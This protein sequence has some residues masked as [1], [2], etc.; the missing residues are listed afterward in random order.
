[1]YYDV[2]LGRYVTDR[3]IQEQNVK[4][5]KEEG[6]HVNKCSVCLNFYWCNN[7]NKTM[8]KDIKCSEFEIDETDCL[9]LAY[10]EQ[11]K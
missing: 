7:E 4:E 6:I 8:K 11:I 10:K 2:Q 3:E 1:M 9:A 5:C